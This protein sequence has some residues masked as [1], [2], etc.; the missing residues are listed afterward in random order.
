MT[1][2]FKDWQKNLHEARK[3]EEELKG[4]QHK[5]D[6][7]KDG[8][9]EGEDLAKLRNMKKEESPCGKKKMYREFVEEIYEA[10]RKDEEDEDEDEYEDEYEEKGEEKIEKRADRKSDRLGRKYPVKMKVHTGEDDGKQVTEEIEDL[11]ESDYGW[12]TKE[13]KS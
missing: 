3:C 4:N 2:N 11:D 6:V 7:D 12:D 13:T 1:I 5:L 9:I 8:K 10:R